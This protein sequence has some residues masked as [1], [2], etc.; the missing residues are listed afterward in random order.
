MFIIYAKYI[1]SSSVV[2]V[3]I[4]VKNIIIG[5]LTTSGDYVFLLFLLF[6]A[7]YNYI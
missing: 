1:F 3:S 4:G 5:K 2:I 7:G 6:K